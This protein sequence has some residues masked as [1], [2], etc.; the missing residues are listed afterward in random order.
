MPRGWTFAISNYSHFSS[1]LSFKNNRKCVK[2]EVKEQMSLYIWD[3]TIKH[4]ENEEDN[5]N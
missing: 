5:E 4:N 1:T 2:K 3:Y